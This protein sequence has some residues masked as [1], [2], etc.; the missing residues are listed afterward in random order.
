M[1]IYT[2]AY[3]ALFYDSAKKLDQTTL[4]VIKKFIQKNLVDLDFQ[5][6]PGKHLRGMLRDYIR[7]RVGSYRIIAVVDQNRLVITNV[8]VGPR[9]SG[10]QDFKD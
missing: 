3:A 5:T 10:Y 9:R 8:H 2:V 4:R 1:P 6:A 7:F